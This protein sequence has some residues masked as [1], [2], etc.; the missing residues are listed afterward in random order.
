MKVKKGDILVC[1]PGYKAD[2]G[3]L[4]LH[5]GHLTKVVE[6]IKKL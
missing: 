3:N 4:D 2:G 6:Y 5:G 1:L